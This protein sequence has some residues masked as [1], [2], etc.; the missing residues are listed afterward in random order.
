MDFLTVN[1]LFGSLY[2]LRPLGFVRGM[3]WSCLNENIDA[4]FP[5]KIEQGRVKENYSEKQNQE[6]NSNNNGL[7]SYRPPGK[8]Y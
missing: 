6:R 5:E 8:K 3:C 4:T 2:G 1:T 7:M